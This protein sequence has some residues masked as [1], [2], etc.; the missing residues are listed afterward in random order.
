MYED[1]DPDTIKKP[2]KDDTSDDLDLLGLGPPGADA[3]GPRDEGGT[4]IVDLLDG[5][6]HTA[7]SLPTAAPLAAASPSSPDISVDLFALFNTSVG[8]PM[9]A[10]HEQLD[11][12]SQTPSPRRNLL[13]RA[14]SVLVL[15]LATHGSQ[16]PLRRNPWV[17]TPSPTAD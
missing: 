10:A 6:L 5:P 14:A 12:V 15:Q 3:A 1:F 9:S 8:P 16:P 11:E 13:C 2:E 7:P 17:A 4:G